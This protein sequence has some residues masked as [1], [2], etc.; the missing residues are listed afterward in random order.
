MVESAQSFQ[1]T[2]FG[3]SAF[4]WEG[5]AYMARTFNFYIFPRPADGFDARFLCQVSCNF[6][7]LV[8][9]A[10]WKAISVDISCRIMG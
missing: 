2:Q 8:L 5:G 1:I 7:A 10:F 4:R 9:A 3:L 6:G